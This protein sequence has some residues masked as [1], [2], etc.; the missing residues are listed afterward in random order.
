MGGKGRRRREKNYRA[1]HGG[2]AR[3]PPPPDPSQVEAIPSKLRQ[4]M[5]FTTD[6]LHGEHKEA[7]GDA[8]KKK[9]QAV[10]GIKLKANEIKDGSND[11]NLKKSRDSDR[12][13][14]TMRSE[15]GGKKNKKRK[16]NQVTDLRFEPTVD[17]LSGSSK[18]KERKKKY[19]EAKKKK[20]KNARTEE[21][22]DFP[23]RETVKFGDV[24]EAPPKLVTVP[25]GS[26]NL[27]DAS[28][29]RLRL[30]AIETY[31]SRKGWSSRPGAP[32][33][34]PVTT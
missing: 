30:H 16:R 14:D 33:L 29:E 32:Q 26:K 24:V 11:K 8:G 19:F 20:H 31:R 21:N 12:E 17:K 2:P 3:L 25:K 27:L 28:K 23:G 5:S 13:E 10:N 34:P 22:L 9:K 7:E 18:R 4:I 1:A 15:K 6:S